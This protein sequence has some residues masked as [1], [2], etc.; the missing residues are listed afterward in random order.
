MTFHILGMSSSQLTK[1]MIFQRGRA[2]TKELLIMVMLGIIIGFTTLLSL[3]WQYFD[4]DKHIYTV[5][6]DNI[7]DF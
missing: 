2:T 5:Y 4:I 7:H 3:S 1:S 6:I